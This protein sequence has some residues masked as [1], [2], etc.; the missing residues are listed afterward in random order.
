MKSIRIIS[1]VLLLCIFM[2]LF[3]GCDKKNE[4]TYTFNDHILSRPV[5]FN[6][7]TAKTDEEMYI[8]G[9]CEMGLVVPVPSDDGT[10]KW[11][12]E[13]ASDVRDITAEYEKRAEIGI[14]ETEG[15]VFKVSLREE[16]KWEDG[17]N[18]NADTYISSMEYL[19]SPDMENHKASVYAYGKAGLLG[20]AG[21][22]EGREPFSCVGMYKT[23]EYEF[24]W[25]TAQKT[26]LFD[27]YSLFSYNFI[28]DTELYEKGL[29]ATAPK[30]TDYGTGTDYYTSYGPYKLTEITSDAIVMTRN[31]NWYGYGDKTHKGQYMTTDIVCRIIPDVSEALALF[32]KGELDRVLLDNS[33]YG[34]Y[35]KSD[36]LVK[37]DTSYTYRYSINKDK[38]A[39]SQLETEGVNKTVLSYADFRKA[40]SLS[41]DRASACSIATTGSYPVLGLFNDM[42]YY[43]A[44]NDPT[45]QYRYSQAAMKALSDMY[46]VL[47]GEGT[48]LITARDAYDSLTGYDPGK[49]E[50]LFVSALDSAKENG[51]Y[52]EGQRVVIR[53]AVTEGSLTADEK[54]EEAYIN[55]CIAAAT[56]KTKYAG[57][58]SV[59]YVS[60]ENRQNALEEGRIEAVKL[61][62]GGSALD[63]FAAIEEYSHK[64]S[65][66]NTSVKVQTDAGS[67]KEYEF[68]LDVWASIINR[69]YTDSSNTKYRVSDPDAAVKVLAAIERAVLED[70]TEIPLWSYR[71]AVLLSHRITLGQDSYNTMWYYGGP[72]LMTFT[73][74]DNQW[75]RFVLDSE[76]KLKYD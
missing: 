56:E 72:A 11:Q 27:L 60:M 38:S 6:P 20:A 58:I 37:T 52:K 51:D 40:L 18:I 3:Q 31:E 50:K 33:G 26:D 48:E 73:H 65:T 1:A 66:T 5:S 45:S 32:E 24:V 46:G 14:T 4:G 30:T 2:P 13:M 39:L 8:S 75:K 71:E 61:A 54:N 63:P 68:S 62:M 23:G 76:G 7:H 28:V 16:A 17:R 47:Y 35:K 43:N 49:A 15:R 41:I 21:Y 42:Y 34:Q 19:L 69:G 36:R 44:E 25:I 57:L 53:I 55:T 12:Y 59:E 10:Y 22:L 67:Y 70:Y 9:F 64:Y 29:S 74:T